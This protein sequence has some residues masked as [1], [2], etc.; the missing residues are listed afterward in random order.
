M[1]ALN[2]LMKFFAVYMLWP[3]IV[4]IVVS[5]CVVQHFSMRGLAFDDP[6]S[7]VSAYISYTTLIFT[8]MSVAIVIASI[9]FAVLF[10]EKR[11]ALHEKVFNEVKERMCSSEDFGQQVSVQIL[12]NKSFQ[13]DLMKQLISSEEFNGLVS[14]FF[15]DRLGRQQEPMESQNTQDI[16]EMSQ[17]IE[18]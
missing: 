9:Y 15:A 8:I 3:I 5:V 1:A 12:R 4:A 2:K 11:K 17:K 13:A 16:K 18:N 6:V 14:K 7:V 10:N